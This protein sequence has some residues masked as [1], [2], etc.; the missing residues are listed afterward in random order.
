MLKTIGTEQIDIA[1]LEAAVDA[2]ED[3]LRVERFAEFERRGYKTIDVVD[4]ATEEG[5]QRVLRSVEATYRRFGQFGLP[6]VRVVPVPAA[7]AE[8]RGFEPSP[9][10]KAVIAC[11]LSTAAAANIP[12]PHRNSDGP[13]FVANPNAL[14]AVGMYSE[15][16]TPTMAATTAPS[17]GPLP[18]WMR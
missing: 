8:N 3:G 12:A 18:Y 4:G 5:Q 11:N 7:V 16:I 1:P 15:P 6:D 14:Q 2:V 17:E 13:S 10:L 9:T